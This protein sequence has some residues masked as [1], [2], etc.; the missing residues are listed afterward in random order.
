MIFLSK[1]DSSIILPSLLVNPKTEVTRQFFLPFQL[2]I[3]LVSKDSLFTVVSEGVQ[4]LLVGFHGLFGWVKTLAFHIALE[5]GGETGVVHDCNWEEEAETEFKDLKTSATHD[6]SRKR[7]R[8]KKKKM[9]QKIQSNKIKQDLLDISTRDS[10]P[11]F[12]AAAEA[13][14]LQAEN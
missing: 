5:V 7:R 14:S 1:K 2:L 13:I 4:D 9:K 10:S 8:R 11:S 12:G 6:S 3:L